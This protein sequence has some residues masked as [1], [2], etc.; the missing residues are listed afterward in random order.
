LGKAEEER[1][2]QGVSEEKPEF[3]R[4]FPKE[5][6]SFSK[7]SSPTTTSNIHNI[8]PYTANPQSSSYLG[9]PIMIGKSKKVAFQGIMDKVNS[10]I[11]GWKAKS[12]SQAGRLTLIK[13]VAAAIPSY[14]MSTFIFPANFCQKLDQSFKNF[15]WGFPSKKTRNLTLKSWVPSAFQSLLEG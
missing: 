12:L 14:A 2:R 13:A 1:G 15:W 8:F 11:E 9:L 7:N 10:K 4:E 5:E 6:T 3:Q